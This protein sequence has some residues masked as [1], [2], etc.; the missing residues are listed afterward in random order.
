ML[1][2]TWV[3][4]ETGQQIFSKGRGDATTIVYQNDGKGGV[5]PKVS[6]PNDVTGSSFID[7]NDAVTRDIISARTGEKITLGTH[8]LITLGQL[9][10]A[11]DIASQIK[12]IPAS[13]MKSFA[14]ENVKLYETTDNQGNNYRATYMN[15]QTNEVYNVTRNG[16]FFLVRPGLS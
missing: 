3:D 7:L 15:P 16:K 6:I 8:N 9:K 10:S 4:K 2:Q 13:G 12:F 14:K 11:K 1:P 5:I